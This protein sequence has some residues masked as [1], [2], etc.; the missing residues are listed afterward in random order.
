[1]DTL[2]RHATGYNFIGD[3]DTG[4]TVRWGRNL[5]ENPARAPWPELVDISISNQCSKGCDFCY[6]DSRPDGAVM[7]LETYEHLLDCLT[8]PIW[9]PPFQ[10]AIGGGEPLEHP[11]LL[12]ILDATQRR[13]IVANF[14]TNGLLL[15]AALARSLAGRVG[16]VAMSA[17]GLSDFDP[18]K[19]RLLHEAGVRTNLHF[20]LDANTLPQALEIAQG[21]HDALLSN[22]SGVVFLARKPKGRSG[23]EGILRFEDP[24][25]KPFLDAVSSSGSGIPLGFDACSVPLLLNHGGIDP[26]TVDAC[27]CGFFSVY[28]DEDLEVRP[29]S[30]SG[31]DRDA[32][33]LLERDFATIWEELFHPYRERQS[34]DSCDRECPGREHCRGKCPLFDEISFCHG[35]TGT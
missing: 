15:D 8:S 4:V 16:A 6:R 23:P 31:S 5:T 1:M 34:A 10:V 30:F 27:E 18:S 7:S 2:R 19:A 13:G 32:W 20:I 14:T 3:P 25:L 22:L 28:V 26:R 29:C 21:E 11:Q 17:N 12:D 24:L 33:N 9:G 35:K